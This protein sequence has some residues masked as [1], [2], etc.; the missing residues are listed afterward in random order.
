MPATVCRSRQGLTVRSS[1]GAILALANVFFE[2]FEEILPEFAIDRAR[3]KLRRIDVDE[4]LGEWKGLVD[5]RW[6]L[7]DKFDPDGKRFVL[8]RRNEPGVRG[9][10]LLTERERHVVAYAALGHSDKLITYELGLAGSTV[11][12]LLARAARKLGART[13]DELIRLAI[14]QPSPR[15][16]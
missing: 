7:I 16:R 1:A 14:D 5:G 10:A 3:G 13:R 2:E 4:A 15:V 6:S 11:R 8:A 12:V 9:L